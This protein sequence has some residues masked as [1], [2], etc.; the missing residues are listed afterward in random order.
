M[1]C[2]FL[3]SATLN[4]MVLDGERNGYRGDFRK[5]EW[6]GATVSPDGRWLFANLQTP[7]LTVAITGP[8]GSGPL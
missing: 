3:R 2:V 6:C 4:N 5:Q 8:W 1:P 7:G